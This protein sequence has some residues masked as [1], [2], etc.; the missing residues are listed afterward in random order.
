MESGV[1]AFAGGRPKP[2]AD[3]LSPLRSK[4]VWVL[5]FNTEG[6]I[7]FRGV[8]WSKRSLT[9]RRTKNLMR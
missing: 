4:L 5:I 6:L 8:E 7:E 2:W 3:R 1:E 9:V